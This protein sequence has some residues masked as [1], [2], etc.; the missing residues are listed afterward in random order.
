MREIERLAEALQPH[1]H[2]EGE[3]GRAFGGIVL[4]A[5]TA[6]GTP[7][8]IIVLSPAL[9]AG[10]RHPDRF[11][12]A[13]ERAG[14]V[15]H[16]ALVP[17]LGG[18]V[19]RSGEA[20]YSRERLDAEPARARLARDGALSAGEVAKI[21]AEAADAL[22][23]AHALGVIHGAITP[24]TLL[25]DAGGARVSELGLHAALAGAGLDPAAIAA[26]LDL[27]HYASPEALAGRPD[28][29]SDVYSLGAVLYEL[30][31]GRPPFGGRTTAAVMAGVLTEDPAQRS[32]GDPRTQRR[33]VEAILRAIEQRPED[34]WSSAAA[35]ADALRGTSET[36]R[37][38]ARSR[39]RSRAKRRR[40][41][42]P[43]L[44]LGAG[45]LAVLLA[46]ATVG[47]AGLARS[48]RALGSPVGYR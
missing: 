41:C 42:L 2:V 46:A 26:V 47:G 40:G 22:G 13:L 8:R 11:T 15:A 1:Y 21:G 44:L 17:T 12:E 9:A 45:G 39:G 38:S 43:L 20:F 19:L 28:A 23:A 33:V 5:L 37:H 14:R 3:A 16:P 34:R 6:E 29:R 27:A 4:R 32:G 7:C 36:A 24:E 18:G 10:L 48:P 35:F 30:L 25:L 31:T